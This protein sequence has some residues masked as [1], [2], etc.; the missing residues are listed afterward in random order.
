MLRL[1]HVDTGREMRGGQRQVLLLLNGLREAGEECVLLSRAGSPL[2]ESAATAGHAV[3]PATLAN[4][5]LRSK[6]ADLVHVHD[7]H[8]HTQAALASRAPFVVSRRVAFPL[9][10]SFL[11][12]WKYRQAARFVAVSQF[13]AGELERAHIAKNKIGVVYDGVDNI[14]KTAAWRADYPAV[15]LASSDP[16]KGRDLVEQAARLTGMRV[17]YSNDL[18]SD[19]AQASMFIYL[20]RAEGFGSAALLAMAM[21][22]PVIASNVGG[23]PEALGDAGLLVANDSA[24]I[25]AAMQRLREDSALARTL[26]AQG[27]KRVAENFTA[28][29]MVEGTIQVYRRVLAR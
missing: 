11:S 2:F 18:I 1:V 14:V 22:I 8:A 28:K 20:T 19:L 13:V 21:G 23:L 7:A 17:K 29:L 9:K 26:I 5:W 15:A 12:H 16:A 27:K 6:R 3:Y 24:Q 25:S 4:L 10:R